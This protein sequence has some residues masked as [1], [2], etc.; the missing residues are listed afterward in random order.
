MSKRLMNKSKKN[1]GIRLGGGGEGRRINYLFSEILHIEERSV[2]Y[3]C[4]AFF[5]PIAII[6][7][8]DFSYL[9]MGCE[10]GWTQTIS[11]NF[12]KFLLY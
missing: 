4:P 3:I 9:V 10:R 5:G 7:M 1:G 8:T 2:S 12:H 11:H 6:F